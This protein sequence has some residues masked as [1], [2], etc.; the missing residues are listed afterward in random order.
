MSDAEDTSFKTAPTDLNP[1]MAAQGDN[2]S[3]DCVPFS[4]TVKALERNLSKRKTDS[5]NLCITAT[6]PDHPPVLTTTISK[7]TLENYR[8]RIRKTVISLWHHACQQKSSL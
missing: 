5:T 4:E 1:D 8:K 7:L 6:A 2:D 3:P